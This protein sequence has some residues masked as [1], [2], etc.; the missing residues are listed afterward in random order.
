MHVML[1][2]TV[3]VYCNADEEGSNI[4]REDACVLNKYLCVYTIHVHFISL[5]ALLEM[6]TYSTLLHTVLVLLF[7]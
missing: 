3:A 2:H 4:L 1:L 7:L 5:Q 6:C